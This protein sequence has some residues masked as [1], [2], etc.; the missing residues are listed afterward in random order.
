M[1]DC[2]KKIFALTVD[3]F[4]TQ[5]AFEIKVRIKIKM[6]NQCKRFFYWNL[7]VK[8]GASSKVKIC[9][10][11]RPPQQVLQKQCITYGFSRNQK[12]PEGR[13]LAIFLGITL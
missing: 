12:P 6:T 4:G 10:C 1:L 13:H 7:T 2:A 3:N 11:R 9:E 5:S 8:A